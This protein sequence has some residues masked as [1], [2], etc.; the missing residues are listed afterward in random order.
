MS[1]SQVR[2]HQVLDQLK[3]EQIKKADRFSAI[4]CVSQQSLWPRVCSVG[5]KGKHSQEWDCAELQHCQPVCRNGRAACCIV[6]CWAATIFLCPGCCTADIAPASSP[7]CSA[8]IATQRLRAPKSDLSFM[9]FSFPQKYCPAQPLILPVLS[10]SFPSKYHKKCKH[11]LLVL[12]SYE[13]G[14]GKLSWCLPWPGGISWLLS[15]PGF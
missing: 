7:P 3:S 5:E 2:Q 4:F 9:L 8:W 1:D 6:W 11:S 15:A 14:E 10:W 13:K 12:R